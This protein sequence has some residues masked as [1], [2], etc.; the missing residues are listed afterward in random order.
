[1]E[2]L[3]KCPYKKIVKPSKLE[4]VF[5]MA[6]FISAVALLCN[7]HTWAEA[8]IADTSLVVFFLVAA[9]LFCIGTH[10]KMYK[11]N[12]LNMITTQ[13][14]LCL[15]LPFLARIAQFGAHLA[16]Q[17]MYDNPLPDKELKRHGFPFKAVLNVLYTYYA[18][19]YAH[20][21]DKKNSTGSD[22]NKTQRTAFQRNG[23]IY[24]CVAVLAYLVW[25]KPIWDGC[26][27]SKAVSNDPFVCT[28]VGPS[29]EMNNVKAT[30]TVY[31]ESGLETPVGSEVGGVASLLRNQ[32]VLHRLDK[33]GDICMKHIFVF[34]NKTQ[35]PK[36]LHGLIPTIED[37][38]KVVTPEATRAYKKACCFRTCV[39]VTIMFILIL[40]TWCFAADPDGA[41]KHEQQEEEQ[42]WHYV[43]V[44]IVIAFELSLF[45]Y[46]YKHVLVFIMYILVLC[47]VVSF[48]LLLWSETQQTS[49][50][51][52]KKR[53]V[54]TL[55]AFFVRFGWKFLR[56]QFVCLG[57]VSLVYCQKTHW[58]KIPIDYI[59]GLG[60]DFWKGV[61]ATIV[62]IAIQSPGL[63]LNML[64]LMKIV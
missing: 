1:M 63:F 52:N 64:Q 33:K 47:I 46:V 55:E 28:Y 62:A 41:L 29:T 8:N 30:T 59:Q 58:L 9:V 54:P 51:D 40:V 36:V 17:H 15:L 18:F 12:S 3:G 4:L 32:T 44:L 38:Q 23:Q 49:N 61:A 48:F 34:A 21:D 10:R 35:V 27:L 22:N 56:L 2:D 24:L 60:Q 19:K 5:L 31:H 26:L 42:L 11:L 53:V 14:T 43:M 50:K 20:T 25:D 39:Y 13:T 57:F 16:A 45:L 6:A 7:L 37:L